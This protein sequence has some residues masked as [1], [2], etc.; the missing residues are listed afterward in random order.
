[1]LPGME[2]SENF[3]WNLKRRIA[4]ERARAMRL[5]AGGA[6]FSRAWGTRFLAGAAAAL[7]LFAAG[8]WLVAGGWFRSD[9]PGLRV[10]D[11]GDA[12]ERRGGEIHYTTTGYP[13]GIRYVSDDPLGGV[14]M[15]ELARR[16]PFTMAADP[17]V[18]Y[19]LKENELLRRQ[20]EEL[21]RR[22]RKLQGILLEYRQL[23]RRR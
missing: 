17:R 21:G 3:E 16:L 6:I 2:P 23:E 5:Q 13:A 15:G 4:V 12:A 7:A 11:R 14:P 8:A 20:L 19:L 18:D 10:A 22:N 1:M 9:A